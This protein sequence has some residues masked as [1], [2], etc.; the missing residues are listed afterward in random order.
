MPHAAKQHRLGNNG[1]MARVR[2]TP[3]RLMTAE[4]IRNSA[5]WQRFRKR[6]RELH[7]VC[8]DP[9]GAHANEGRFE[10]TEQVHHVV[11]LEKAPTLAF[12]EAN[13]R[14]LCTW[15]HA[16]VGQMER[17]GADTSKLFGDVVDE[18]SDDKGKD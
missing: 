8:C 4:A 16:Q 17:K 18:E 10:K 7:P 11:P 6:F 14:P 2:H 5:R 1:R 12:V 13:C 9:F 15:C 3:R